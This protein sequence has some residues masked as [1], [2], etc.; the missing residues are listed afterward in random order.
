MYSLDSSI[1][2]FPTM[3]KS[4]L[5]PSRH[6]TTAP[7]CGGFPFRRTGRKTRK[8]KPEIEGSCFPCESCNFAGNTK[9]GVELCRDWLLLSGMVLPYRQWILVYWDKMGPQRTDDMQNLIFPLDLWNQNEAGFDL[10]TA[11][12]WVWGWTS[13]IW[14]P[15]SHGTILEMIVEWEQVLETF[16]LVW[17]AGIRSNSSL[18]WSFSA[19]EGDL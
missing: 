3:V 6:T 2:R 13:A 15:R 9:R 4:Y 14:S 5:V 1:L 11:G 19:L 10:H 17:Y 18:E 8:Y 7:C 16:L 12:S